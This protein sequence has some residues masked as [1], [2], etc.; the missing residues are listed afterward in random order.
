MLP[1]WWSG[2]TDFV[3]I[4]LPSSFLHVSMPTWIILQNAWEALISLVLVFFS[5]DHIQTTVIRWTLS[6]PITVPPGK[7]FVS[8]SPLLVCNILSVQ[9]C[10][11]TSSASTILQPPLWDLQPINS[12]HFHSHSSS[13]ILGPHFTQV[14][15]YRHH[16][17]YLI[18]PFLLSSTTWPSLHHSHSAK[19][20][21]Y[22]M[23]ILCL[24]WLTNGIS[25]KFM[26]I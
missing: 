25:F 7:V 11:T 6:F 9:P 26:T 24:H 5:I 10:S 1:H 18:I 8:S 16:C 22:S 23:P 20:P 19:P 17:N 2:N 15:W 14:R 3:S 13:H 4:T 12:T 21:H